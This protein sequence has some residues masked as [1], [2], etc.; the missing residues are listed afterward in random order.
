[1]KFFPMT[2]L[3]VLCCLGFSAEPVKAQT[4]IVGHR[5]A[6]YDAPENTMISVLTAIEQKADA[7]EVD[8]HMS[9]DQRLV[10]IH[11]ANTKRTT[12]ADL[13]VSDTPYEKLRTLDAGSFKSEDFAGEPIPLLD[14][15]LAVL[16]EET[17]L[18]IEIK[19]PVE[20]VPVLTRL[21]EDYPR[22]NQLRIIA[23]D[24]ETITEAKRQNPDIPCYFLKTIV[25]RFSYRKFVRDLKERKLDGADL[26]YRTI[27]PKL[28]RM[29]NREG[30]PCLA[31]TVNSAEQA[32]KLVAKGVTG[33]TTDRPAFI[34]EA[35]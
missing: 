35:L 25:P 27:T 4:E 33:I 14:D 34:R 31:W 10:V 2:C 12:G 20:L 18:Y 5:G 6:A 1:M 8:I 11:D 13:V 23:F 29:L 32:R 19:G 17:G 21:L 28:V 9:A 3:G 30:M 7:V 22:R 16:P 26:Y 15:V 24:L